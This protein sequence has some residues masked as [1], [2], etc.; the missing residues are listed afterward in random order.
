MI[1]LDRTQAPCWQ[2]PRRPG[3]G[4]AWL[5]WPGPGCGL[6]LRAGHR[7]AGRPAL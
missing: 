6:R 4:Q 5:A 1:W 2:E 3:A 7:P